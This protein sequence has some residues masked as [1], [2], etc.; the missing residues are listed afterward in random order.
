MVRGIIGFRAYRVAEIWGWGLGGRKRVIYVLESGKYSFASRVPTIR[1][2]SLGV[3]I[4][5]ILL[6]GGLYRCPPII[7]K[8]HKLKRNSACHSC[9][10]LSDSK[11]V[12]RDCSVHVIT[13]IFCPSCTNLEG[14]SLSLDLQLCDALS[15]C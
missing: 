1:G 14:P 4:L 8:Y 11:I 10:L 5:R 12:W 13:W 7:A 3:P 15:V 9:S 2:T 6:F